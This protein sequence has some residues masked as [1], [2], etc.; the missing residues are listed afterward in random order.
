MVHIVLGQGFLVLT[1]NIL[2]VFDPNG[3]ANIELLVDC[4]LVVVFCMV[5]RFLFDEFLFLFL[6]TT[7]PSLV[8]RLVNVTGARILELGMHCMFPVLGSGFLH[9]LPVFGFFVSFSRKVCWV[10]AVTLCLLFFC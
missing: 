3:V 6:L 2:L 7:V 4:F 10:L 1:T 9:I 8:G 5:V